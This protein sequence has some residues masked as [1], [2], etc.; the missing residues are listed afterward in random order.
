MTPITLDEVRA[1]FP[2]HTFELIDNV[3]HVDGSALKVRWV[4]PTEMTEALFRYHGGTFAEELKTAT[5]AQI[6]FE[7]AVIDGKSVTEACKD[8]YGV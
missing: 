4:Q 7:L 5:M 1:A 6:K 8:V 3:L 2:G